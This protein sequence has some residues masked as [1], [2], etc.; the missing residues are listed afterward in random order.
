MGVNDAQ[1]DLSRPAGRPATA[2]VLIALDGS[3][4]AA[5]ALPFARALAAALQL[6]AE[7]IY[8]AAKPTPMA[9]IRE[10]LGLGDGAQGDLSLQVAVGEPAAA[11]VGGAA[12]P[13]VGLLVM[14]THGG[15]IHSHPGL[16][17]IARAVAAST[18]VPLLLVR[19]EAEP[20]AGR[21]RRPLHRLLLPLD[22]DP[23]SLAGLAPAAGLAR[24]LGAAVDLLHVTVPGPAPAGSDAVWRTSRYSDAPYYDWDA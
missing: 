7:V 9:T 10:Q 17:S 13:E 24:R 16:G 15:S 11:I 2:R 8:A 4:A 12:A 21:L 19:P 14:A 23:Q 22:A 5:A 3:A 1:T 6:P 18:P 20:P